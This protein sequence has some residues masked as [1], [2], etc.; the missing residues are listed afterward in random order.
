MEL[1]VA[2]YKKVLLKAI[3]LCLEVA[4]WGLLK[5]ILKLQLLSCALAGIHG[6]KRTCFIQ[7]LIQLLLL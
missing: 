4:V 1:A 2:H 7:I 6:T 3:G 5:L